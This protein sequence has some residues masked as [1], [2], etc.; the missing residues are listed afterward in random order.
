MNRL[1]MV[2]C[3]A[4]A[5]IA[6]GLVVAP[7]CASDPCEE[8]G[9]MCSDCSNLEYRAQC[10][11]A[12]ASGNETVCQS[13][14]NAFDAYC[15]G[16]SVGGAPPDAGPECDS[17]QI[18]CPP[19]VCTI[20]STDPSN[21]G[22]CGNACQNQVCSQGTC[23]DEC[24]LPLT[25]CDGGCVN[26]RADPLHCGG[27]GLACSNPD[28]LLCSD[29]EC[30]AEC[31]AAGLYPT[32]CAGG[33]VNLGTDPLH[34][35]GCGVACQPG[36][37]CSAGSCQAACDEG[38]TQCCGLCV[39]TG[40][41][42]EHCGGCDPVLC[43][44]SS[45]AGGAGGDAGGGV[46]GGGGAGGAAAGGGGAGGGVPAADACGSGQVCLEGGC[47]DDCGSFFVDCG[48][49]CVDTTVDSFNCGGCGVAC[50]PTDVCTDGV[51]AGS[52]EGDETNCFGSCVNLSANTSHCGECGNACAANDKCS[53]GTCVSDCAAGLSECPVES[54]HCVNTET[55]PEFCGSCTAECADPAPLCSAGACVSGCAAGEA[56]CS[57][58][59]VDLDRDFENCGSCG[60]SCNDN[61]VCTVDSCDGQGECDNQSAALVCN[62]GNQCTTDLCD[63]KTGCKSEVLSRQQVEQ[64]CGQGAP[65]GSCVFCD[66]DGDACNVVSKDDNIACTLDECPDSGVYTPADITHVPTDSLCTHPCAGDCNPPVGDTLTGCVEDSSY[67]LLPVNNCTGTTCNLAI[68]IPPAD[69]CGCS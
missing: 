61:S 20:L 23:A 5:S 14:V 39:N 67:C 3:A 62:D 45:G 30:V 58:A 6:A 12:A 29:G 48:G 32:E 52:C 59:C 7:G 54:G 25:D 22:A 16:S 28:R 26:E 31:E 69:S 38:L 43:P 35:G 9:D 19:G 65:P 21:C 44:S 42:P 41:N 57:G 4:I 66:P 46:G 49:A 50:A 63:P 24:Q 1:W 18:S 17:G 27:C 34:C 40:S 37:V 2:A 33:C 15:A 13:Q 60:N 55:N 36:Q 8:L 51:C 56:N 10:E 47:A 64:L 53:Q 68:A 11:S